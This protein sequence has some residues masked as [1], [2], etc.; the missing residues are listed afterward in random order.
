MRIERAK[1]NRKLGM[2]F[3]Q[4]VQ[5]TLEGQGWQV[6]TP[7]GTAILIRRTAGVILA[8]KDF[9]GL[10]DGIAIRPGSGL[11]FYQCKRDWL[12]WGH[13]KKGAALTRDLR[14]FPLPKPV[15][16]AIAYRMD[17]GS[18]Q[19]TELKRGGRLTKEAMEDG[20]KV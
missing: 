20:E 18:V 9:F 7:R 11:L 2:E 8:H 15:K 16:V 14:M 6:C 13:T 5:E 1:S 10:F 19:V 12:K 17:D 4:L 3:E